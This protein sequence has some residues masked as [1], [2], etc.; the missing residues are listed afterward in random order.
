MKSNLPL[1]SAVI[2]ILR[3]KDGLMLDND[4]VV[5]IKSRY[6]GLIFSENEINK[7]LMVLETQGL[8]HVQFITKNKRRIMQIKSDDVY[9]GVEED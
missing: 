1:R 3:D 2:D 4:L 7:A 9:M 5:A 6:G 8:I